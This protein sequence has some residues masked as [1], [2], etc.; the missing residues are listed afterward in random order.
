[1]LMQAA[2]VRQRMLSQRSGHALQD[3]AHAEWCWG[4]VAALVCD[5]LVVGCLAAVRSRLFHETSLHQLG[6][7]AVSRLWSAA[8]KAM[9][10]ISSGRYPM[11]NCGAAATALLVAA[12][13]APAALPALSG[14]HAQKPAQPLATR[15]QQTQQTRWRLRRQCTLVSL[16]ILG[17]AQ[18]SSL[19]CT[20]WAAAY[21]AAV[22]CV[23]LSMLVCQLLG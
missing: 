16:C 19:A 22:I 8:S 20:N 15:L 5:M 10:S 12:A 17:M 13:A 23:P 4:A 2:L 11:G 7:R 6:Y 21:L 14:S 3:S 18:L 1:M 9:H